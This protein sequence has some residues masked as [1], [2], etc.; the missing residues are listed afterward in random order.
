MKRTII[1]AG[2]VVNNADNNI[3]MIY[4]KGYWDLPKGKLDEGESIEQ[5]AIREVQ[6]ETG[7][8]TIQLGNFICTTYHEYFDPF[9]QEE[10]IKETHWFSMK[11]TDNQPL[12]PQVEE[13]ITAIEWVDSIRLKNNLQN[14]YPNIITVIENYTAK[15]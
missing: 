6:E 8:Q 7:L 5:C 2:G 10:V 14:T 9:L 11:I 3:L 13:N 4:R 1:A 15:K 12:V